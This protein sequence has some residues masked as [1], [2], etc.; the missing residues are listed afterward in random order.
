MK[1]LSNHFIFD[2]GCKGTD[3]PQTGDSLLW[4]ILNTT[5]MVQGSELTNN[6]NITLF[7]EVKKT[8]HLGQHTYLSLV[9]NIY[10]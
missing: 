7:S 8:T 9:L 5:N 10:V 2:F 4:G 1:F 6:K 3:F